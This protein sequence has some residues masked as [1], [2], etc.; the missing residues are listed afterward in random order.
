MLVTINTDASFNSDYKLGTFSFW[1]VS[2]IGRLCYKGNLKGEIARS[3]EAE[4]KAVLNALHFLLEKSGWKYVNKIIINTDCLPVVEMINGG[5]TQNWAKNFKSHFNKIKRMYK[6]TIE[7]RKV[8]AHSGVEERR[9][10]V[11]DWCD[12]Q[13]KNL[14]RSTIKK[15]R[16]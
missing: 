3:Q 2:D 4:F 5:E 12:E 13:A 1:I 11:N 15:I 10:W 8:K 16:S 14:L 9:T 7:A 6:V